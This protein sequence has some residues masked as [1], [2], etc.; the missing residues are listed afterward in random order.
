MSIH[1]LLKNFHKLI[2]CVA[3]SRTVGQWWII[4]VS[5][6]N[7]HT[8]THTGHALS[9][10]QGKHYLF[11]VNASRKEM[12]NWCQSVCKDAKHLLITLTDQTQTSCCSRAHGPTAERTKVLKPQNR[13]K[14]N[15]KV[16]TLNILTPIRSDRY[17]FPL[18]TH[19]CGF[20]HFFHGNSS[21]TALNESPT[22][23]Y[24]QVD[25]TVN[26]GN[27]QHNARKC[28]CQYMFMFS[29]IASSGQRILHLFA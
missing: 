6:T 15:R 11:D 12:W 25:M 18:A 7:T 5:Q 9:T 2:F 27:S 1:V 13:I 21:S 24:V 22:V 19:T 17:V 16:D 10:V 23:F 4:S 28:N 3:A 29:L 26:S 8:Y 14:N 20:S